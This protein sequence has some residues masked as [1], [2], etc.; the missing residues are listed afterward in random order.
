[1]E[2]RW[3]AVELVTVTADDGTVLHG[4]LFEP[5]AK[6]RGTPALLLTGGTGAEFYSGFLP[7]LAAHLAEAGYPVLV[8]NRRDHGAEFGFHGFREAVDDL[9]LGVEALA[10]RG[11]DQVVLAGH[12]YGT[13]CAAHYAVRH[14]DPR[15]VGEIWYAPLRDLREATV[16]VLGSLERY[17]EWCRQAE[18]AVARGQGEAL[19]VLP[20]ISPFGRPLLHQQAVFLDKRGPGTAAVMPGHTDTLGG[21]PVLVVRHGDDF[22][23]GALLP[24][25][26][27]GSVTYHLLPPAHPRLPPAVAHGFLG[28]ER[29]VARITVGWLKD[30][31]ARA[32]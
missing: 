1:M 12:S 28:L 29:E 2:T 20:A 8:F 23:E 10:E 27:A 7:R 4:A 21:L 14:R 16:R 15:V 18:A 11:V 24:G 3:Q 13:L 25:E 6:Q 31:G 30:R 5:E 9:A 32:V 22:A 17:R 19:V 26:L